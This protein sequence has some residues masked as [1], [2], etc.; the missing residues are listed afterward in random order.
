MVISSKQFIKEQL[1]SIQDLKEIIW[2]KFFLDS[3]P[4]G[5]Q[6]PLINFTQ[7]TPWKIDFKWLVN[8]F[9][10]ISIWWKSKMEN[11]KIKWIIINFFN[12][13]QAKERM[14]PIKIIDY[15][16]TTWSIND[17]NN[18]SEVEIFWIHI[19]IKLKF[20]KT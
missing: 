7:I 3:A 8:E 13:L 9:Y 19:T 18:Q 17:K 12:W 16:E 15:K 20:L 4:F 11:E 2:D 14:A 10:Q 5:T 6:P 1:E